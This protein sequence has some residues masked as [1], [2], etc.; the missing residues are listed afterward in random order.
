MGFLQAHL[1]FLLFAAA[2]AIILGGL[3]LGGVVVWWGSV[4]RRE[5]NP[6]AF[7]GG[8]LLVG[9]FAAMLM[10]I[11]GFAQWAETNSE[12]ATKTYLKRVEQ[13]HIETQPKTRLGH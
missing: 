5:D 8:L 6:E 4:F 10:F 11:V 9:F 3:R 7:D 12:T 2:V 1:D 13:A